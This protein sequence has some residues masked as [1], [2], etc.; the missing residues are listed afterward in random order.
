[1]FEH[2]G[3]FFLLGLFFAAGYSLMARHLIKL[4]AF[5]AGIEFLQMLVPGRHA[6]LSDFAENAIGVAIGILLIHCAQT[7]VKCTSIEPGRDAVRPPE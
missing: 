1:M 2:A 3:V 4:F 5:V 6:R 7:A